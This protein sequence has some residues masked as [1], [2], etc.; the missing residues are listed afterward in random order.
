MRQV[1]ANC[2]SDHDDERANIIVFGQLEML[3]L[4]DL[5]RLEAFYW[6]NRASVLKFPR[7]KKLVVDG[8]WGMKT[9]SRGNV[10][11]SSMLDKKNFAAFGNNMYVMRRIL[12]DDDELNSFN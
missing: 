9:I 12:L 11:C 6:G 1:I 10:E 7:L 5:R 4:A 3:M 8:C 2:D